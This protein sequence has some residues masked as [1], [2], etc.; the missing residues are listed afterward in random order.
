[1]AAGAGL[2]GSV[3]NCFLARWRP[4]AGLR[5]D[6][7]LDS[8]EP[9]ADV[10]R[11][12]GVRTHWPCVLL[13]IG[14]LLLTRAE[15][16]PPADQVDRWF[17]RWLRL[18]AIAPL[19]AIASLFAQDLSQLYLAIQF[20]RLM[21]GNGPTNMVYPTPPIIFMVS[22][23]PWFIFSAFFLATVG[24]VPLAL[25]LFRHLRGLAKR[26]RSAHLAEHC[27]IVGNGTAAAL[28]YIFGFVELANNAGEWGLKDNLVNSSTVGLWL[29]VVL[30]VVASLFMMWCIYLLLRFAVSFIAAAREIHRGLS[31]R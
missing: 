8:R 30:G 22:D 21:V 20:R 15:G 10:R 5:G 1:M 14:V 24:A 19:V 11:N 28:V 29:T 2:G 9:T 6:L 18:A 4:V 26:A 25:L 27:T 3:D 7:A 12:D 23:D 17:R 13:F 16:Y 31:G